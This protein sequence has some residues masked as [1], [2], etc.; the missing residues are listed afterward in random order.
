[1]LPTLRTHEYNHSTQQKIPQSYHQVLNVTQI[2]NIC[3]KYFWLTCQLNYKKS[4][5]RLCPAQ[6]FY[7]LISHPGS[8]RQILT[9]LILRTVSFGSLPKGV[10]TSGWPIR[11][12]QPKHVTYLLW[13][14]RLN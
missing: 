3:P 13:Q 1:M 10:Q 8:F 9:E 12:H 14:P 7:N 2:S 4:L 5:R 6:G 11:L